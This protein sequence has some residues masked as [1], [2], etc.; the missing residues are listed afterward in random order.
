MSDKKVFIVVGSP[1]TGTSLMCAVLSDAGAD[2]G[3]SSESWNRTG[4]AFE[5][6]ILVGSYKYLKRIVFLKKFSD[7][8]VRK[9]EKKLSKNIHDLF[10]QVSFAKFPPLSH[11][12]PYYIKKEGYDVT[13]ILAYRR[14]EDFAL[15]MLIKNPSSVKKLK[16]DY[17]DMYQTGLI[18]L[19]IHG[20][21]AISYD[22]IINESETQWI[23]ALAAATHLDRDKIADARFTRNRKKIE[24]ENKFYLHDPQCDSIYAELNKYKGKAV[25]K[26]R[27]K[28]TKEDKVEPKV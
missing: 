18:L 10:E 12:L 25:A 11:M 19:N 20:G 13:V 21:C 7:T 15:S 1:R 14:F 4:G 3:V 26:N 22:E 16:E 5:H 2:F 23:D 9:I 24:G 28:I 27:S 17:I 6:P 8:A